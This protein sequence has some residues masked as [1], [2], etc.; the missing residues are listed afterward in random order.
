MR[1]TEKISPSELIYQKLSEEKILEKIDY[2]DFVKICLEFVEYFIFPFSDRE[3]DSYID[4]SKDFLWGRIDEKQILRYQKEAFDD[5]GNI[6]DEHEKAIQAVICLC[7]NYKFLTE[8]H[9]KWKTESKNLIGFKSIMHYSLESVPTFLHYIEAVD[10]K[11]CEDFYE[12]L[13]V[14]IKNK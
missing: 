8:A 5:F 10:G 6:T 4:Y 12:Y 1:K 11:L 9:S 14:Y 3:L 2:S 7:L 13:K